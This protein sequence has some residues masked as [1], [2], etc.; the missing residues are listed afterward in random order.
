[1]KS[2]TVYNQKQS[3]NF[4]KNKET[5]KLHETIKIIDEGTWH[6]N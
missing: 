5:K 3:S 2:G 6:K 4:N 1:M